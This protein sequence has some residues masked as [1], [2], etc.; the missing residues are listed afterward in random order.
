MFQHWVL[1]KGGHVSLQKCLAVKHN[2]QLNAD[3]DDDAF[4]INERKSPEPLEAHRKQRMIDANAWP[5]PKWLRPI[6]WAFYVFNC[7]ANGYDML[8]KLAFTSCCL[9]IY[10]CFK[11]YTIAIVGL[12]T[13]SLLSYY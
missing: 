2:P 3:V 9:H 10:T 12:M 11:L 1:S 13:G 4:H 5:D 7:T 6:N 8:Q